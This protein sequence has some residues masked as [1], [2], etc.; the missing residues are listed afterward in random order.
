[1]SARR[2]RILPPVYL[3]AAV[4]AML[5]LHRWLP[6]RQLVSGPWRWTGLALAILGL[7]LGGSAARL[8]RRRGTTI[9]PGETSTALM[10]DGPFRFTRNPIYVGMIVVLAGI[11]VGL[12][13][14]SP[15]FVIPL[16]IVAIATDVIPAEEAM[17][18]ETFGEAYLNYQS[19]VR[20]WI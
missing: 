17:L 18:G 5:A 13:S 19:R 10:T 2:P 16:F 9:R 15:W 20:R 14:L 3:L 8:F 7:A 6:I 1:M 12:G 4:I 11:A